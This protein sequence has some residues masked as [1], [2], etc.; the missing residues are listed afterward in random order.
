MMELIGANIDRNNPPSA[1]AQGVISKTTRARTYVQHNL[2][3]EIELEGFCNRCQ[4]EASARDILFARLE[5]YPSIGR[6]KITRLV[7][8]FA[9]NQNFTELN[10]ALSLRT[11]AHESALHNHM[12]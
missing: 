11:R 5:L 4:L 1:S 10:P 3:A 2:V 12:I 8:D 6:H 7:I 9:I